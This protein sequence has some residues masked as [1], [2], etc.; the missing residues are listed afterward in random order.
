RHTIHQFL[1]SGQS[2]YFYYPDSTGTLDG[3]YEE[4]AD[5]LESQHGILLPKLPTNPVTAAQKVADLLNQQPDFTLLLDAY[6]RIEQPEVDKFVLTLAENLKPDHR[7]VIRS[8]TLPSRLLN[9]S[10]SHFLAMIPYAP[11]KL[12]VD[13]TTV[14]PDENI[15]EVRSL[16]P[17][18]ALI[19]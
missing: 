14:L 17:G 12:L 18:R 13:Y 9:G 16:G 8:R 7:V 1:I 19:D 2:A 15:L 11:D 6:D 10:S 3:F 5:T 4:L